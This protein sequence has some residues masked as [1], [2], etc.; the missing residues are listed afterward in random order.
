RAFRPSTMAVAAHAKDVVPLEGGHRAT[1]CVACHADLERRGPPGSFLLLA[2]QPARGPL[3]LAVPKRACLD[4]HAKASPH[5]DQFAHRKDG[6]ACEG[7]HSAAA[8]APAD[9]FDHEKDAGF[10]L[11]GAHARVACARCHGPAAGDAKRV[12]YRPLSSKCESCHD[13]A[14]VRRTARGGR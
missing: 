5:G 11:A 7:C 13:D 3:T 10:G 4:C 8:F 1:P 9:R 6:G 12:L 14:T 2:R